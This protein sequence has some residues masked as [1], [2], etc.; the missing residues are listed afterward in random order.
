MK[1]NPG[2]SAPAK[3][4]IAKPFEKLEPEDEPEVII[5]FA[6]PDVISGL[7]TLAN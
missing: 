1:N 3:W 6:S 4:L 2:I 7:F 5:F